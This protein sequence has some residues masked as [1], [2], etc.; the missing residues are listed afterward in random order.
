MGKRSNKS[1]PPKKRH[2]APV[3]EPTDSSETDNQQARLSI[4]AIKSLGSSKK[5]RLNATPPPPS[6]SDESDNTRTQHE[7]KKLYRE[8]ELARLALDTRTR[9]LE[10]LFAQAQAAGFFSSPHVNSSTNNF[11]PPPAGGSTSGS[12]TNTALDAAI[13]TAPQPATAAFTVPSIPVPPKKSGYSTKQLRSLMGYNGTGHKYAWLNVRAKARQAIHSAGLDLRYTWGQLDVTEKALA[14]S[15]LRQEV[16]EFERFDKNWGAELLIVETFNH[17]RGHFLEGLETLPADHPDKGTL[18]ESKKKRK[19]SKT[20]GKRK[21]KARGSEASESGSE[22]NEGEELECREK[23]KGKKRKKDSRGTDNS[24]ENDDNRESRERKRQ[25]RERE[26]EHEGREREQDR[27]RAERA[28]AEREQADKEKQVDG[29]TGIKVPPT[30]PTKDASRKYDSDSDSEWE[31]ERLRRKEARRQAKV[32]ELEREKGTTSQVEGGRERKR[33]EPEDET[34]ESVGAASTAGRVEDTEAG[35]EFISPLKP[36][37]RPQ[38]VPTPIPKENG[39]QTLD[40]FLKP[41]TKLKSNADVGPE[42]PKALDSES[43]SRADLPAGSHNRS[44]AHPVDTTQTSSRPANTSATPRRPNNST[45]PTVTPGRALDTRA[46]AAAATTAADAMSPTT[47]E[48]P[49]KSPAKRGRGR[50]PKNS[51]STKK[52]GKKAQANKSG[53]EHEEEEDAPPP[54]AR[55]QSTRLSEKAGAK[56]DETGDGKFKPRKKGEWSEDEAG[57]SSLRHKAPSKIKWDVKGKG[58]ERESEDSDSDSWREAL[59][60]TASST[61]V[62]SPGSS[63]CGSDSD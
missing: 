17:M 60:S 50:P 43:A 22:E 18:M 26:R 62:S 2:R 38:P 47:T 7:M 29:R 36:P 52:S 27:E 41:R 48:S 46:L 4:K 39:D 11:G 23:Q 12:A 63:E 25:E 51:S 40:L 34:M 9:E 55:R 14:L 57:G 16:P 20:K 44:S 21:K 19:E 49:A 8:S 1:T 42:T 54:M 31:R 5:R 59:L 35:D 32:A 45:A 30:A 56:N 28:R 15:Q 61:P 6:S 10:A 33:R 58:K 24:D 53:E 13:P 3:E 37:A